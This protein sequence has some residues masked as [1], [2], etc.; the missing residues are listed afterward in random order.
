MQ[1]QDQ[2]VRFLFEDLH[3]RGEWVRLDQSVSQI[4]QSHD[5]PD[6]V[7]HILAEL[8]VATSLLTATLKFEGDI[9]VQIQGDGPVK[10]AV[11]NGTHEQKLRGVARVEGEVTDGSLP[12]MFGK[13]HL[14][15]TL[16]P[17]QGER[18]Q[19]VVALDQPT[20]A[21]CIEAYFTQ[22]E[23]L[24]TQ[25]KLF[26]QK[27]DS[28]FQAAGTFL[29]R[30]PEEDEK[31]SANFDHLAHLNASVTS[32]EVFTLDAE[33]LLYRLYHQETVRVFPAQDVRFE[34]SCSRQKS[35]DA[36]TSV[37]PK[38]LL[39]I[40]AQ[41]KVVSLHCDYCNTTYDFNEQEINALITP[42]DSN[43]QH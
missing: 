39:D 25:V 26:T 12:A 17:K 28:G 32:E 36:L 23:Q 11:I 40:I 5:Y 16:T 18:Y 6:G 15:I 8:M 33:D 27:T 22:S 13:G 14:V 3:V 20:L 31:D 2:L 35:A 10:Y 4:V 24:S 38:E 19:G 7:N 43:T 41:D 21:E 42:S 1:Q 9:A 37:N 34:C 30:L 29:Q